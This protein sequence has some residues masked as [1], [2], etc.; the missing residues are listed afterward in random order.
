MKKFKSVRQKFKSYTDAEKEIDIDGD[1]INSDELDEA[2]YIASDMD[3]VK[4]IL[5]KIESD[6]HRL[7]ISY[8]LQSYALVYLIQHLCLDILILSWVVPMEHVALHIN[9]TYLKIP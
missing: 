1:G 7:H 4:S 9:Q 6:L 2:P 3:I 5:D 8:H